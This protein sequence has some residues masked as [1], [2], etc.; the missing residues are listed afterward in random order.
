MLI[1]I[2]YNMQTLLYL[3]YSFIFFKIRFISYFVVN[4][5]IHLSNHCFVILIS[6][7][8]LNSSLNLLIRSISSI[9]TLIFISL[10][11]LIHLLILFTIKV[12]SIF[13]SL[14]FSLVYQLIFIILSLTF[15]AILFISNHKFLWLFPFCIFRS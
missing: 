7:Y 2:F 8:L 11:S 4:L 12:I 5:I 14:I 1:K 13:I 3:Y 9:L 10:T 6:N 15:F